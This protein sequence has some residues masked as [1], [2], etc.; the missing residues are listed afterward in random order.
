M[1][2]SKYDIYMRKAGYVLKIGMKIGHLQTFKFIFGN[3]VICVTKFSYMCNKVIF[4][5]INVKALDE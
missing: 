2:M 4:A 5:T 3:S 1:F